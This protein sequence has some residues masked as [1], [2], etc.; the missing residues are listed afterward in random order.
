MDRCPTEERLAIYAAGACEEQEAQDVAA[1]LE[2]C[3]RCRAL[4]ERDRANNDW[5]GGIRRPAEDE[6][7]AAGGE[8]IPTK[9]VPAQP[10]DVQV[11]PSRQVE[12][13]RYRILRQGCRVLDLGCAPGSWSL[14]ASRIVGPKG[15]VVGVDITPVTIAMPSNV[16]I[17]EHDILRFD[18]SI[19]E[20]TGGP[21]DVVLS[22]MA[23]ST[24]GNRFVDA[25]R[26][27]ELCEAALH[28]ALQLLKTKGAFVCKVFHGS[29]FKDFSN[30]TKGFFGRVS[31]VRPKT[32]RKA[33]KEIF[34]VALGKK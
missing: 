30:R 29:D 26:S 5:L 16:Q 11:A 21:F 17:V 27:L 20:T 13:K 18:V 34:I 28:I 25:Q 33:S 19:L 8:A 12:I 7:V 2:V 1:H 31:H 22:D 3:D 10:L 6:T 14:F 9:T 15:L 32:T 4:V 24:T 23:P